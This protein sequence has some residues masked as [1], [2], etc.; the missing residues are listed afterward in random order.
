MKFRPKHLLIIVA[1]AFFGTMIYLL[2]LVALIIIGT[3]MLAI[4]IVY[5]IVATIENSWIP[6]RRS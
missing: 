2:P 6:W 3:A 1:F 5:L 4:C